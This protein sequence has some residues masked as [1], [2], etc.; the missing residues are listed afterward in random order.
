GVLSQHQGRQIVMHEERPRWQG[1][2]D[3]LAKRLHAY[4]VNGGRHNFELLM[5]TLARAERGEAW[6]ELDAP[7]VFPEAG[8][9]HPD[10]PQLILPSVQAF[11]D[12]KKVSAEQR[13][14]VIGIAMQRQYVAAEQT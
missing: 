10:Y 2:D 5:Q 7:W 9:Y 6:A 3:A 4:F 12:W 11:L 14:P 8:I 1:L 13:P